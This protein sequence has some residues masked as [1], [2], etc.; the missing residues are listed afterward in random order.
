MVT[1]EWARSLVPQEAERSLDNLDARIEREALALMTTWL[2]R[3][4]LRYV[5]R[6]IEKAA[7]RGDRL[8]FVGGPTMINAWSYE[9]AHG[10]ARYL[11][12]GGFM[13]SVDTFGFGMTV[14]V[15]W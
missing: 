6:E 7:K 13:A 4:R 2:G 11:Q 12:V 14:L 10:V 15:R 8:V 3:R 5:K 1:A 9:R